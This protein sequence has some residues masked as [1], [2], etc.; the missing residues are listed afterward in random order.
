MINHNI[1]KSFLD[2]AA[3]NAIK[4]AVVSREDVEALI[5]GERVRLG[6]EDDTIIFFI[7]YECIRRDLNPRSLA[8]EATAL[9]TTLRMPISYYV[10]IYCTCAISY[11][12]IKIIRN[13][14][15]NLNLMIEC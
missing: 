9:S 15:Y 6:F 11:F 10:T 4:I 2:H 7:E 1:R 5:L 8:S 14:D 3:E 12:I 13:F